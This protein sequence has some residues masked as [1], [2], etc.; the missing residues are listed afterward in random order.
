MN[1]EGAVVS[2]VRIFGW[3]EAEIS[4]RLQVS[5][6]TIAFWSEDNMNVPL[7]ALEYFRV[8]ILAKTMLRVGHGSSALLRE[9]EPVH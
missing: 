3:S 1:Q 5:E 2:W 4:D 8:L 9:L 6:D 7:W